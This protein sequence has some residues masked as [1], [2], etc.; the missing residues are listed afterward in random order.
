M[1][2]TQNLDPIGKK[3]LDT[4]Q[5]KTVPGKHYL[6]FTDIFETPDALVVVMEMPGVERDD[7][8]I[9]V[10]KD[11]LTVEGR[12]NFKKYENLQ[13]VYTEYNVGHYTRSFSL[14]SEIDQERIAA[15]LVDGVLTLQLPKAREAA[16]RRIPIGE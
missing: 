9:R 1:A 7:L 16:P 3:E 11:V 15:R 13:P 14:S 12:I 2:E 8:E 6:P 10:E 4:K 5:E